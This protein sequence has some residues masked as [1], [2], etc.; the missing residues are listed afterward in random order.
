MN[1]WGLGI[2]VLYVLSL[3]LHLFPGNNGEVLAKV[4]KIQ[5]IVL[6]PWG[7]YL[8]SILR[9]VCRSQ[10]QGLGGFWLLG[11]VEGLHLG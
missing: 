1:V 5:L 4:V 2:L 8:G 6:F 3:F 10:F 9:I 11:R 7:G